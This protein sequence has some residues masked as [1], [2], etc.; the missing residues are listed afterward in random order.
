[1]RARG[2]ALEVRIEAGAAPP[3]GFVIA[4]P[5]VEPFRRAIVNGRRVAIGRDGSVRVQRA[6]ALVVFEP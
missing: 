5:S 6:P 1:M 2:T 3:G 4:P